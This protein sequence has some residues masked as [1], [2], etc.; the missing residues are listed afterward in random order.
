MDDG[1]VDV[2]RPSETAVDELEPP[3]M[4]QPDPPTAAH[5][6]LEAVDAGDD[7]VYRLKMT[8]AG[9]RYELSVCETDTIY[10][11][12]LFCYS[13]TNVPPERQKIIGLVKGKLPSDELLVLDLHLSVGKVK[14]FMLVGTPEG[15]E[16][17][18]LRQ[19]SDILNDLDVDADAQ[20]VIDPQLDR[21]NKRRIRE[22]V[23][24]WKPD[25]MLP[26]RKDAKLLV[27]DLDYTLLDCKT[28][29]KNTTSEDFA[30]PGLHEFLRRV[31][32]AKWDIMIWSQTH[33]RYLEQKLLELN[34]IGG[35]NEYNIVTVLDRQTM[36]SVHSNRKGKIVRH[37]VKA[38]QIIWDRFPEYTA[39][40][41]VHIDDLSR[42]AVLQPQNLLKC[43]AFKNTTRGT[44]DRE[45]YDMADYLEK[46]ASLDD[47]SHLDHK[48]FRKYK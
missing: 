45:L 16:I 13:L 42:N 46:I 44:T 10:D 29:G 5:H 2:T 12:K 33:W 22:A 36:F 34:M 47:L 17:K 24:K 38:L 28:W 19:N 27:L 25:I 23:E 14:D 3:F 30:R 21:R 8:H 39:N 37:E 4:E 9:T 1:I 40:N 6:A 11:L 48:Q 43:H 32:D 41:T 15:D 18:E 7:N 20:G 35:D 26:P 31:T